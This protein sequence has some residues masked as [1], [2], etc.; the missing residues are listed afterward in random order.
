MLVSTP[1]SPSRYLAYWY[2]ALMQPKGIK[3]RVEDVTKFKRQ[4][5][6]A[7]KSSGDPQ[8]WQLAIIVPDTSHLWI[9]HKN[10]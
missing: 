10:A 9:I 8:L 3:L 6:I 7:R 2:Q 1:P 5:Y 4:L